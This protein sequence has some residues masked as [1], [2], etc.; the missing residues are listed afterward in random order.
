ME[1]IPQ[2]QA[3]VKRVLDLG[4]EIICPGH[5][6][7]LPASRVKIEKRVVKPMVVAKK[8]EEEEDLEELTSGLF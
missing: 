5:G 2:T 7:P 4:P 8:K 6:K 1:S 3:S